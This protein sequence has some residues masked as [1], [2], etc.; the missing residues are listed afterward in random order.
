MKKVQEINWSYG[1][2]MEQLKHT[3]DNLKEIREECN[4]DISDVIIFENAIKIFI[5]DNIQ[6]NKVLPNNSFPKKNPF[7]QE[8]A[9]EKQISLIKKLNRG[10]VPAGISKREASLLIEELKVKYGKK[11]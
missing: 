9:T 4:L 11:M 1:F 2:K 6:N 8:K 3:I 10:I 5:S 7:S